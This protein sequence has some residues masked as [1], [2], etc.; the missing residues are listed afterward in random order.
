LSYIPFQVAEDY[1]KL[2]VPSFFERGAQGLELE[3]RKVRESQRGKR[4]ERRE[5]ETVAHTNSTAQDLLKA[6]GHYIMKCCCTDAVKCKMQLQNIIISVNPGEKL[7][8]EAKC[9]A[10]FCE[11]ISLT[12]IYRKLRGLS[13]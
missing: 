8:Y 13:F 3:G 1:S 6:R 5:R 12:I 10:A 2:I 9:R 11:T 4:E 7:Q